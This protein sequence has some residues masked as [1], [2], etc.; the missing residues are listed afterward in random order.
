MDQDLLKIPPKIDMSVVPRWVTEQYPEAQDDIENWLFSYYFWNK[1]D[2]MEENLEQ[3]SILARATANAHYRTMDQTKSLKDTSD[4]SL[5]QQLYKANKYGWLK[6]SDAEIS[7]V[8]ELLNLMYDDATANQPNGGERYELKFIIETLMPTLEKL[9][10]SKEMMFGV[11]HNIVKARRAVS[12]LRKIIDNNGPQM[13]EKVF[14]IMKDI[15][16]PN[17]TVLQ[18]ATRVQETVTGTQVET[19]KPSIGKLFVMPNGKEMI[20]IESDKSKTRAIEHSLKGLVSDFTISDGAAAIKELGQVLLPKTN[21]MIHIDYIN[22]DFATSANS[23]FSVPSPE[24]LH[25]IALR[26]CLLHKWYIL[27]METPMVHLYTM[28]NETTDEEIIAWIKTSFG[29]SFIDF[30]S[31]MRE[32]YGDIIDEDINNVIGKDM[33]LAFTYTV[34]TRQFSMVLA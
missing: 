20:I 24:E 22:P 28:F 1:W 14:A 5:L 17:I 27:Q 3:V 34:A 10:A 29:L 9:G 12:S 16:D 21:Q 18:C 25:R 19:P 32:F 8:N 4:R 2:G 30:V 15:I 33:H 11:P 7:D 6:Y 23:S 31:K 13:Q 26:E